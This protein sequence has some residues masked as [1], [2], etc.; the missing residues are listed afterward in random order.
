[1]SGDPGNS[2]GS[3]CGLEAIFI[4][5]AVP[6]RAP[7]PVSG[8]AWPIAAKAPP[9]PNRMAQ[10]RILRKRRH[11][12]RD[13]RA[14]EQPPASSPSGRHDPRA[15]VSSYAALRCKFLGC[16]PAFR[17]LRWHNLGLKRK[18]ACQAAAGADSGQRVR[19][20]I[21]DHENHY[22]LPT[23]LCARAEKAYSKGEAPDP[24]KSAREFNDRVS[25]GP[26]FFFSY[27]DPCQRDA[28]A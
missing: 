26:V 13:L 14:R 8:G 5:A 20:P 25:E 21:K 19:W 3:H 1:M 27:A 7:L 17:R 24:G 9:R 22:R 11:A 4:A 15:S 12:M 6:G 23:S 16:S 18:A 2:R 28:N 10:A